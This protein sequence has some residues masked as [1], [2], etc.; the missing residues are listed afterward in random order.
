MVGQGKSVQYRS[1]FVTNLEHD[2]VQFAVLLREAVV[3]PFMREAA[4]AWNKRQRSP[5]QPDDVSI[6]NIDGGQQQPIATFPPTL[7]R[8]EEHT[9]GLQSLMRIS[10]AVFCLKKKNI[11]TH[12]QN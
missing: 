12:K 9:S 4:C 3:A 5:G 7:G 8:S 6:A 1:R 10:Y 11:K 2:F